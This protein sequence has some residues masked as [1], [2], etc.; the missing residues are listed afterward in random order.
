MSCLPA[1]IFDPFV[2]D[3]EVIPFA[4]DLFHRKDV[5][6]GSHFFL[7][8][9]EELRAFPGLVEAP[10]APD[11]LYQAQNSFGGEI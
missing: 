1:A 7:D 6:L 5:A 2:C 11:G 4:A 3:N 10:A 8:A 9:L